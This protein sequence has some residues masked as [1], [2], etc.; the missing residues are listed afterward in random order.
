M[1]EGPEI[2]QSLSWTKKHNITNK[3]YKC[4]ASH[5]KQPISLTSSELKEIDHKTG[6]KNE[7]KSYSKAVRVEGGDRPDIYYICPKFWD[8]KNQ[9]PLD[10]QEK[11]HP[12]EL[13][14]NGEKKVEYRQI[15]W[16]KEMKGDNGDRYILERSGR[17][18][19]RPDSDSYWNKNAKKDDIGQY[20][21]Q[22]IHDD[23]HPELL[24]LPCCGKKAH[25][26]TSKNVSVIQT[27]EGKSHWMNGIII[28]EINGKDEYLISVSGKDDYY[29]ITTYYYYYSVFFPN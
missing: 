22:Y 12:I 1:T 23:V 25:Q 3:A 13:D 2:I 24:P 4:Q 14:E 18:A 10:P 15:V 11:Y 8:R 19:N 28:G 27:K 29:H 17:P 7:G 16:S 9:I 26:I 20:N 21:V 5:D 6:F